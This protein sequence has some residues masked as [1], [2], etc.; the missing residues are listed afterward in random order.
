VHTL[1]FQTRRPARIDRY[2]QDAGPVAAALLAAQM[3]SAMG[4]PV[5]V[6]GGLWG[7]MAVGSMREELLPADTKARLVGFTELSRSRSRTRR[8][9][10]LR[11]FAEEQA[12]L[13]RVATL[14]ARA[15][16]PEQVFAAVAAE[17]GRVLD[18]DFTLSQPVRPGR[19]GRG[20]RRM[21]R[22]RCY[23]TRPSRHPGEPRRAERGFVGAEDRPV[24]APR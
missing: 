10:E 21:E 14:V 16:P 6:D 4:V 2:G 8:R 15:A 18:T 13:R 7:V 12:A 11:G 1:V 5:S 23:G 24:S 22:H 9:V 19:R 20:G 3:R 17:V